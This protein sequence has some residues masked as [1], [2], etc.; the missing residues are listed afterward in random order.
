MSKYMIIDKYDR[1][2][3]VEAETSYE[4]QLKGARMMGAKK[5]Y[6]VT[7]VLIADENDKPVIHSTA[8]I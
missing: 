5:N 6:E 8:S 4:A 2:G 1:R 7:V 3:Y